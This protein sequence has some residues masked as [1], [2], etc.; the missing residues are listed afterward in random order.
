M[1][2]VICR[3]LFTKS[4]QLRRRDNY[5]VT[6]KVATLKEMEL[7]Y[8]WANDDLV[9]NNSLNQDVISWEEHCE[10]Y[11]SK[12]NAQNCV[13]NIIVAHDENR[14]VGQIRLDSIGEFKYIDYSISEQFRG[15]GYGYLGVKEVLETS[16]GDRFRAVVKNSN[17]ASKRIFEKLQFR[18]ILC[19]H[20]A[21]NRDDVLCFQ[22]P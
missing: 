14:P 16:R 6:L 20:C 21:V 18:R 2:S 8:A 19:C 10:W 3:S 11:K 13:I 9:R 4:V 17:S 15:N 22:W 12:L 1:S 7:L 5:K